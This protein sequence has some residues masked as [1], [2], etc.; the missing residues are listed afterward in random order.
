MRFRQGF[1]LLELIVAMAVITLLVAITLGAVQQARESARRSSC[2][3][4]LRQIGIAVQA[5]AGA[6]GSFPPGNS[7]GFSGLARIL[8][9]LEQ[10]MVAERVDYSFLADDP[11]NDA[12]RALTVPIFR[13]PSDSFRGFWGPSNYAANFGTGVQTFGYNGLFRPIGNYYLTESKGTYT[14]R[15][16]D[17]SDGL[18]NTAAFAEILVGNGQVDDSRSAFHTPVPMTAPNEL[19]L[20]A[21]QCRFLAPAIPAEVV[22]RGYSWAFGDQLYTGYNH[23]MTPG[24]HSCVNGNNTQEGCYTSVSNHPRGVG[25]VFA[26]G[27]VSF[28]STDVNVIIWRAFGSRNGNEATSY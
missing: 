8:P 27:H 25:V 22:A 5:Y 17:V 7:R 4:H 6:F 19:D 13:C 1:T 11:Q 24:Q 21:D 3:S 28:T 20:F 16:I 9:Y 12:L 2:S 10:A 14:V 15:D 18:S 26:D 23:I